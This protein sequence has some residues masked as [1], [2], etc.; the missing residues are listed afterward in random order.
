MTA[1][2]EPPRGHRARPGNR[3]RLLIAAAL[4][5]AAVTAVGAVV[6]VS[7]PDDA[8]DA[9]GTAGTGSPAVG[10]VA[11]A[12]PTAAT[13]TPTPSPSATGCARA[14]SPRPVVRVTEVKVGSRVTGYGREGDTE[15]LPMAVAARPDGTSWLAWTG[16]D[17]R[18]HLARLGCDDRMTGKAVSVAGIDLQDVQADAGGVVVLLTR[19][20][21][22][23]SGPLCGGSSSPCNTMHLVRFDNGGRQV[24]ERQVTNLGGGRAGYDPGARFVWWYQHHGRLATDGTNW[25]AYFGVAITV[26]NGACVDIHEGDRMQVVSGGGALVGG[27]RDSFEVG[28]SHSWTTRIVWDPRTSRFVTVCAT[29]NGCRIARPNPYRTVAKGTCDGTLFGGDLVLARTKGYWTAWSQGGQVR[30]EHFTTGA[31]DDTVRTAAR[32][33]HPHLVGY[34]TG[35]MLLAWEDGSALAAQVYDT[36]GGKTVGDRFTI[37]VR[38]HGYQAFKAYAD[39]SAAYP[40]AGAG[41]TSIRVARVMPLATAG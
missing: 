39:G 37:G 24:W 22:C 16:T 14:A 34:G 1:S 36:T 29:D 33:A 7:T 27:H 26:K 15:P 31:S 12:T 38:D 2:H 20:G 25:A 19:R 9:H 4:A 18:I 8:A 10:P 13:P 28:C 3:R 5:V 40:A 30:L 21:S 17:S 11:T 6:W 23:G 41:N 32:G 35:H